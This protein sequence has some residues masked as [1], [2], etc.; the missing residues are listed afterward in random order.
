L[1][2]RQADQQQERQPPSHLE[3]V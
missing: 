3:Q 1:I 2:N